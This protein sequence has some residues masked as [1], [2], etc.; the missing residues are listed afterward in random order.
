MADQPAHHPHFSHPSSE[1]SLDPAVLA[2]LLEVSG[3]ASAFSDELD[4]RG[5]RGA[6]PA[7]VVPPLVAGSRV[8]GP[9]LTL[10]YLPE[11]STAAQLA[12]SGSTGHLGNAALASTARKG[13]VAVIDGGGVTEVSLLGGLAAAEALA[14]GIVAA[15][16]D[17]AVRDLDEIVAAGLPVWASAR[18]PASGRRR[19]EAVELNGWIGFGGVQVRPGDVAVADDSG[20]CFVPPERFAE[21]AAAVLGNL[22]A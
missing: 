5:L 3:L 9:A 2:A 8:V 17:G 20:I 18:T 16:V 4:A 6:V 1:S 13:Q 14:S 7:S 22:P 21:V 10:R 11:R 15:L 19:M 12:A